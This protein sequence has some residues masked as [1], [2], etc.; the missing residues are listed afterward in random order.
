MLGTLKVDP[1]LPTAACFLFLLGSF[2]NFKK[3]VDTC[4]LEGDTG[5]CRF[6]RQTKHFLLVPQNQVPLLHVFKKPTNGVPWVHV[7]DEY[8]SS[9]VDPIVKKL[10]QFSA[11]TITEI[12][13]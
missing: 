10:H 13:E 9:R 7:G 1:R 4:I 6:R 3:Y 2:T 11:D 8:E 12:V 5:D